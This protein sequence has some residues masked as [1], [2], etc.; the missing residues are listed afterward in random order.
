MIRGARAYA[1]RSGV[2]LR[3]FNQVVHDTKSPA[4]QGV[5]VKRTNTSKVQHLIIIP[6]R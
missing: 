3:R 1:L 4:S 6:N 2:K 5:A